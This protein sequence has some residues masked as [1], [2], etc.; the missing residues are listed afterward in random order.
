MSNVLTTSM[1][2]RKAIESACESDDMSS[3]SG[4][5]DAASLAES[6]NMQSALERGLRF[7]AR[8]NST[9]V[10]RYLIEQGAKVNRVSASSL[11]DIE[12]EALPSQETLEVLVEHGWDINTRTPG[13]GGTPVLWYVV[14]DTDLVKWCLDHGAD[15]DPADDTS[16]GAKKHRKP[17]LE[18]AAA[19]G[20]I[21]VFEL[22][23][24]R[25]APLDLQHGVLPSAVMK[26]SFNVPAA[27]ESPS[28]SFVRMLDMIRHLIDV[29]GCDV[30][31]V[32]YGTY[33][34]SGSHCSTPLCWVACHTNSDGVR[35]LARLLLDRGGD[36]DLAGPLLWGSEVPSAR[37]AA[38]QRANSPFLKVIAEWEAEKQ[39]STVDGS[40]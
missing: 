9:K 10:M 12:T 18:V 7:A 19:E 33:C 28:A 21:E 22:L 17:I 31:S 1:A 24:A 38:Q 25:G 26:A 36:L 6:P 15:V 11:V 34:G 2:L 37:E 13:L 14:G 16:E 20:N 8:K 40:K 30:N 4:C 35:D 23:R 39:K 5:I 32:S 3:S 29:I 27:G